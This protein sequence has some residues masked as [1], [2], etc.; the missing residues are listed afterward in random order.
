MVSFGI[1]AQ[2]KAALRQH[3]IKQV[4]LENGKMVPIQ[5]AKTIVLI[6]CLKEV[7]NG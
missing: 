4:R 2:V 3:G 6:N 7:E 5:K 1:K